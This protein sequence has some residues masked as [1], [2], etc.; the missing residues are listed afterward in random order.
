MNGVGLGRQTGADDDAHT[1]TA[2]FSLG[3]QVWDSPTAFKLVSFLK[4]CLDNNTYRNVSSVKDPFRESRTDS[5]GVSLPE[6]G[7]K[8]WKEVSGVSFRRKRILQ[9]DT[10]CRSFL[11]LVHVSRQLW[12][13]AEERKKHF[14]T[15]C[16]RKRKNYFKM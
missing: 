11:L 2:P 1:R 6:E 14:C 12:P 13:E 9:H 16:P 4:N 3:G 7:R 8:G 5:A 15:N 10:R